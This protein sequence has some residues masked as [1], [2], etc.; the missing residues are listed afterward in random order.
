MRHRLQ[1]RQV[2]VG[3]A[4]AVAEAVSLG[5]VAVL[6]FAG[7]LPEGL[8]AR[9]AS[10]FSHHLSAA[11]PAATLGGGDLLVGAVV[12]FALLC[13]Q[14][15]AVLLLNGLFHRTAAGEAFFLV[16][17]VLS[18]APEVARLAC[19]VLVFRGYAPALSVLATRIVYT[20]R[21]FGLSSLFFAVLC[22]LGMRYADYAVL[23]GASLLLSL[24]MGAVVPVDSS[25]LT[26]G[27]V[28]AVSDGGGL[29]SV[30]A[31]ATLIVALGALGAPFVRQERRFAGYAAGVL[32][33]LAA[34]ELL[35]IG[36]IGAAAGGIALFVGGTAIASRSLERV[37]LG[38]S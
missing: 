2:V 14:V 11:A 34:R 17:Y 37:Y 27:L 4:L 12:M 21:L 26:T 8:P 20:G 9:P 18:L 19:A 31:T 5:A 23:S 3:I 33:L 24:A 13:F 36:M 7:P 15:A 35:S 10:L 6:A 22:S 32:C 25:S 38:I 28:Y 29:L 16:S 1:S 30:G